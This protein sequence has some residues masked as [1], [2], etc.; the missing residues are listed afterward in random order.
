[1]FHVTFCGY[2]SMHQTTTDILQPHGYEDYLLLLIKTESFYEKNGTIVDM[3]PNTV[4]IWDIHSYIHYGCQKPHFNDDWVQFA[5]LGEDSDFLQKLGLPLDQPF[6]VPNMGAL[7]EYSKLIVLESSSSHPYKENIIDSLVHALLYSI[8]NQLHAEPDI[9]S[10]NKYYY[11]MNELRMEILNAPYRQWY[12]SSL[13]E[14]LHVSTSHFQHLYKDFF[15]VTCSQDIISSRIRHAQFYLRTTEMSIHSLATFCG[16]DNEL[17]FMRQ[18][19]KITGLTPSQYRTA[20]QE[21][22]TQNSFS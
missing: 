11:P 9:H 6:T 17:H 21:E 4:V 16:Y 19:K 13:A 14:K 22:C 7:T 15:G 3:P 10:K 12:I 5:Q 18:F 1:M 20:C 8:A 2:N